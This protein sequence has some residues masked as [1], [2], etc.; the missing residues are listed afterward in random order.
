[1]NTLEERLRQQC[2]EDGRRAYRLAS[3]LCGILYIAGMSLDTF[4]QPEL[5]A[6]LV[7]IRLGSSLTYFALHLAARRG[8]YPFQDPFVSGLFLML[9]SALSITIMC[10]SLDGYRSSY[11]AGI[12]LVIL[13]AGVL[14]PWNTRQ[15]TIAALSIVGLYLGLTLAWDG[16]RID[17]SDL[18]INNTYFLF[19]TSLITIASAWQGDRKRRE[20]LARLM[21]IEQAQRSM[22]S[23]LETQQGDIE[24]ASRE[25]VHALKLQDE[26]LSIASH[27]LK[28]PITSMMLQAQMARRRLD[29]LTLAEPSAP[30]S[31]GP[32][33]EPRQDTAPA[34]KEP[35]KDGAAYSKLADL[36]ISQCR[37]LAALIDDMLDISRIRSG[38]LRMKRER[39]DL[40]QMTRE[41]ADRF[42]DQARLTGSEIRFAP[43]APVVGDWD[44][45]RLEQ[46]VTNL[47]TNAIKYGLGKPIELR[48]L[49]AGNQAVIE[50]QDQGIGIAPE[51]QERIF[52]RFERAVSADNISG[53][54]LGLYITRQIVAAHDGAI[55]VR[56][57][58]GQGATFAVVLPRK[59]EAQAAG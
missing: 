6:R 42:A 22:Q 30:T 16:F 47:I 13:G 39:F 15:M 52:E 26:F 55:R 17:R 32:G 40:T 44:R 38:N 57:E 58:L 36:V 4:T 21:S 35:P 31:A 14:F 9:L 41:M 56:S 19:S 5:L 7:S 25:I 27:E 12:N 23:A 37:R 10:V 45:Y 59:A 2:E 34:A 49:K 11:Y 24:S 51:N 43:S 28:T 46:V 18:L 50:V 33:P 3:L 29:R 48:T 53:L 8:R 20:S 1:M 54:G